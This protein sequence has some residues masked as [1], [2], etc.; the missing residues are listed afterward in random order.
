MV[1][2]NMI[3]ELKPGNMHWG[4]RVRLVRLYSV[5]MYNDKSKISSLECVFHDRT[6]DRIHATVNLEVRTTNHIHKS[7]GSISKQLK[8][9]SKL[10]LTTKTKTPTVMYKVH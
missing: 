10:P 7:K 8:M 4:L 5:P 1:L 2:F 9:D 3:S 6:G